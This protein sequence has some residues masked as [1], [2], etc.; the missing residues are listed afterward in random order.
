M[1][2]F[3][4]PVF[5]LVSR[6]IVVFLT[7]LVTLLQAT[8]EPTSGAIVQAAIIGAI[9]AV[10]EFLTPINKTVGVGSG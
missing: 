10:M 3:D 6:A 2:L 5:R 4:N 7:A 1:K 8:S 9:L